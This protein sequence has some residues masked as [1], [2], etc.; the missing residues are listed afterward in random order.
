[1][2]EFFRENGPRRSPETSRPR[3]NGPRRSP[4]TSRRIFFFPFWREND[5]CVEDLQRCEFSVKVDFR[6]KWLRFRL[7]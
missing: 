3:E 5:S 1:M 6:G 4:E 2:I 7:C